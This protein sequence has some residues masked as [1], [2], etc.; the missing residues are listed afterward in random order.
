MASSSVSIVSATV[1]FM[2]SFITVKQPATCPAQHGLHAISRFGG[3]SI[4][5]SSY[6]NQKPF[7]LEQ[8]ILNDCAETARVREFSII[9]VLTLI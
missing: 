4:D 8:D 2:S 7:P 6:T 5:K 9:E 3:K 1:L